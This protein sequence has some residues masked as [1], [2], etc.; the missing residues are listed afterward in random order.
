MRDLY[1]L[2]I[3]L[4]ALPLTLFRPHIGVLMW[5]WLSLM[6]P[7]RLTW[8]FSYDFPFVKVMA[9]VC[10][11][12]VF[13]SGEKK[14]FPTNAVTLLLVLFTVWISITT[15]FAMSPELAQPRLWF[16]LKIF[17]LTYIALLTINTRE[18]IHALA[19]IIVASIG[20]FGVKGGIFTILT[21]GNYLVYGPE[22]SFIEDNNHL[23]LALVMVLPLMRYLQSNSALRYIRWGLGAAMLLSVLAIL[24]SYSRGALLALSVMLLAFVIRSRR[25]WLTTLA[26]LATFIGAIVLLPEAWHARMSTIGTYSEDASAQERLEIWRFSWNV[27][28]DRPI[29]GGGFD[30]FS[31]PAAYDAYAPGIRKRTAH[32]AIFQV[33]AEHGFIG[34]AIFLA[35][36]V[37]TWLKCSLIRRQTKAAAE[38]RWAHDL[39]SMVQVGLIGFF[40]AGLFLN[41][42]FFDLLYLVIPLVVQTAAVVLGERSTTGQSVLQV[43]DHVRVPSQLPKA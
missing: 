18:R 37:A 26:V 17:A 42:A 24:G 35:L 36:G 4:A 15:V 3:A 25:G 16:V 41:L 29:V 13:L 7:H 5:A 33:L 2:L 30:V 32:S 28:V 39:A 20:F 8:G 23:A 9:I 14:S 31:V 40:M 27:A 12:G 43:P 6:N 21:G 22:G 19:W 11:V 34:L 38:L 10:L 1:I